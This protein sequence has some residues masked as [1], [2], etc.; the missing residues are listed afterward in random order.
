MGIASDLMKIAG[1]PEGQ[2]PIKGVPPGET[3]RPA[4]TDLQQNM[5]WGDYGGYD[6]PDQRALANTYGP[7]YAWGNAGMAQPM[8]M[9]PQFDMPGAPLTESFANTTY[10]SPYNV[11]GIEGLASGGNRFVP[12]PTGGGQ[13]MLDLLARQRE[14]YNPLLAGLGH[15]ADTPTTTPPPE[16]SGGEPVATPVDT[17]YPGGDMQEYIN[18]WI[19]NN[20]D[21]MKNI[22][23]QYPVP[24]TEDYITQQQFKDYQSGIPSL[25]TSN[26]MTN[27]QFQDYMGGY[28]PQMDMSN[29]MTNQ[30]FQDYMG[31][32]NPQTPQMDMS[33]YVTQNSLNAALQGLGSLNTPNPS[34]VNQY[35]P[36]RFIR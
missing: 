15:P 19:M 6:T 20:P 3:F 7:D 16:D 27:Q 13:P 33:N 31:E 14:T 23:E 5:P 35:A 9:P 30:Q 1:F 11:G 12:Q 29:Y 28:T 24:S 25:D 18:D 34:T 26:Y 2:Q 17:T 10:Q 4:P 21:Y 8:V 22:Y 36:S 32:Y